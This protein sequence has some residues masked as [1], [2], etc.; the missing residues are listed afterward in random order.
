MKI[1]E[2]EVRKV[3]PRVVACQ[4]EHPD[5]RFA[6]VNYNGTLTCG[7]CFANELLDTPDGLELLGQLLAGLVRE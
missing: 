4:K 7:E 6:V 3:P 1:G 2:V 5:Q